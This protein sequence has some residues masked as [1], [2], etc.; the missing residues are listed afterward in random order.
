MIGGT[1]ILEPDGQNEGGAVGVIAAT[2]GGY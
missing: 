2:M 1:R